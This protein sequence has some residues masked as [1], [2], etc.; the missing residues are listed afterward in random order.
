[1]AKL[2]REVAKILKDKI[3]MLKKALSFLFFLLIFFSIKNYGQKMH[4]SKAKIPPAVNSNEANKEQLVFAKAEGDSISNCIKWILSEA[5]NSA[6]QVRA[7]E[8]KITYAITA[9]EGWYEYNNKEV[10]WVTPVNANAHFW[11][12]IQDGKWLW[13]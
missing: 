7:G 4:S 9:P 12:F 11:I 13:K 1:L 2:L 5:G 6:G 8:Y 10:N 3:Y